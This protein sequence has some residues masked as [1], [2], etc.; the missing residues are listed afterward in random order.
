MIGGRINHIEILLLCNISH[1]RGDS[2]IRL[3]LIGYIY[4]MKCGLVSHAKLIGALTD[5]IKS[6][7]MNLV[8]NS[9]KVMISH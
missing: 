6:L 2:K 9:T 1:W 8:H 7:D 3:L 5:H 4:L